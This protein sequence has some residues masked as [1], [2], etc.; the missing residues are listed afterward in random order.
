MLGSVLV[1][2]DCNGR[3]G[4]RLAVLVNQES[5]ALGIIPAPLEML[6]NMNLPP[7]G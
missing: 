5:I 4:I 1:S 2:P 7:V 3:I 6:G